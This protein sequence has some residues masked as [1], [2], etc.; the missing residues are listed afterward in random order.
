MS[1]HFKKTNRKDI[2]HSQQW[3]KAYFLTK[4]KK[5][6]KAY[7]FNQ[8]RKKRKEKHASTPLNITSLK[9]IIVHFYHMDRI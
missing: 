2:C 1:C 8:K 7:F 6:S 5:K 4:R 3:R 9:F